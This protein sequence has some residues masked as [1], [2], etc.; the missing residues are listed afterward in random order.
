MGLSPEQREVLASAV[1][2][3]QAG[4]IAANWI[5]RGQMAVLGKDPKAGPVIQVCVLF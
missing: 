2:V 3:D 4:E 1:R 5:Y